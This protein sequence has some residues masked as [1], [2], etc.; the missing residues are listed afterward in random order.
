[1]NEVECDQRDIEAGE[2]ARPARGLTLYL[3]ARSEVGFGRM[4]A[5]LVL[6]PPDPFKPKERRTARKGFVITAVFL[7]AL[8]A[9]FA[10]FNFVR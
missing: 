9:W 5:D 4:L 6:E 3:E 2:A 8:I 10:W 1:M 7:F